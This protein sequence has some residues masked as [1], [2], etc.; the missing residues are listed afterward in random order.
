MVESPVRI[1]DSPSGIRDAKKLAKVACLFEKHHTGRTA[2]SA[3]AVLGDRS[4]VIT[5]RGM[6]SPAEL[7]L[8]RTSDGAAQVIELHQQHVLTSCDALRQKI[9]AILGV[10][11]LEAAL[12]VTT[13]TGTVVDVIQQPAGVAA[14]T[15]TEPKSEPAP[16]NAPRGS[17]NRCWAVR[18]NAA[19]FAIRK[20]FG[21]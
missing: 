3:T 9:E 13:Q 21:R 12:K 11:M 16:L 2:E 14:S 18:A 1:T 19:N 17:E 7:E 10:P 8:A 6:L 4:L 5:L 15:R 20:E